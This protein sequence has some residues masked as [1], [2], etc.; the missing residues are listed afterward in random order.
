MK[1]VFVV[2]QVF[3]SKIK[4]QTTPEDTW[5]FISGKEK[6]ISSVSLLA[7]TASRET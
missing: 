5:W 2:E 1:S 3:V 4:Q 7:Q 6:A